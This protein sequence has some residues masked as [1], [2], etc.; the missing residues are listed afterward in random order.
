[1]PQYFFDS[2]QAGNR[3]RELFGIYEYIYAMRPKQNTSRPN[4]RELSCL[5]FRF[6]TEANKLKCDAR[7]V[8][9]LKYY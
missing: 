6:G 7:E 3:P 2:S 8:C 1:M 9:G 5:L 4:L